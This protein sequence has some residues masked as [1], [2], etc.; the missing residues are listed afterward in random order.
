MDGGSPSLS[1]DVPFSIYIGDVFTN[2]GVPFFVRPT[3]NEVAKISENSSIGSPVFQVMATDP[4]DPN[5]PNGK[6]SYKFLDDGSD[7]LAFKIGLIS[8]KLLLDR[9]QKENYTLIIVIQDHGDNP[10]QATRVLQVQVLDIDDHKPNFQTRTNDDEPQVFTIEEEVDVG[11]EIGTVQA[12]DEDIG[13]NGMID[14]VITYGNEDRLFSINRTSE[15]KGLI[16]VAKRLDREV[17]S[18]HLLTVK[19][20]K[21]SLTPRGL[22]KQYNRQDPSETQVKI[23]VKDVDDN[24]PV[25]TKDNITIGVRLNVPVDTALLTME[26]VDIDSDSKPITYK[27]VNTTFFSLAPSVIDTMPVAANHSM[28]FRL[29]NR[30][31]ELRTASSMVAF[32]DGFFELQVSA[33][34]TDIPGRQANTTVKIFVL[35]DRDLLKFIFSKP[36]TDVRRMLGDFQKEVEKALLLP[37]SLNIYDTQFYA[38]EDGSLDFSS[39]R[40]CMSILVGKES[41]DLNDMQSLLQDPNNADL[42]EVY[43]KYNV[44]DVQVCLIVLFYIIFNDLYPYIIFNIMGEIGI[45]H[46]SY[47]TIKSLR[48]APLIAKAEASWI[49]LWVLAIACFI[50]IGAL[51]AGIVTCCLYG[52]HY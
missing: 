38:K 49:Q 28:V 43:N 29:D 30:T 19:C 27:L 22:Q 52:S 8:T 4:D 33:N 18:E 35:R 40:L 32:V 13:E 45:N 24:N 39:T 34:N 12:I 21:K 9:E 1:M 51:L 36:P 20:F 3:I 7:A 25:F 42:N 50:G 46:R 31:G 23:K 2:D 44:E 41:Y 6:I 14:Y 16:T 15:N 10:Q 26:A 5:T 17:A 11:T 37:V 48:C 47:H